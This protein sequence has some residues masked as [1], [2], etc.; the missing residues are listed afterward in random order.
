M[1]NNIK[2]FY[3]YASNNVRNFTFEYIRQ[4][5]TCQPI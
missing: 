3:D 2:M 4:L 5:S 1:Y